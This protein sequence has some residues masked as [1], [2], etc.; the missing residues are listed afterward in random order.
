MII[1]PFSPK[2]LD[3]IEPQEAQRLS[4]EIVALFPKAD[5]GR[6]FSGFIGDE[7][8]GAAGIR[9]LWPGVGEAWAYLSP[10]ALSRGVSVARAIKLGLSDI[11]RGEGHRRVQCHVRKSHGAA[12][13]WAE[14]LGF[15]V[16]GL[17]ERYAPDGED[18]F[19][20]ARVWDGN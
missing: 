3:M 19:L 11:Q 5:G 10:S 20:F 13:R 14:W 9:T 15:H 12:I 8:L 17:M 4:P 2:H 18:C 6:A 1:L 7:C 16:E